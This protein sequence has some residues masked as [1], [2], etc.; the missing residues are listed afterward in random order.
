MERGCFACA[1]I[2]ALASGLDAHEAHAQRAL[3]ATALAPNAVRIDGD[4]GD[5]RGL[6]FAELGDDKSGSL[7]YALGADDQA[8]YLAARVHDDDFVRGPAVSPQQ[9]ALVLTFWLPSP[10][11]G[12][13]SEVW[14]YAGVPGQQ[15]SVAEIGPPGGSA[16]P[17]KQV[18]VVEG[19]LAKGKGYVLEARVP[20][21]ALPGGQNRALARAALRLHDVDGKAG[22]R[23]TV[24][25]SASAARPVQLPE[26]LLEG[27]PNASVRAFLAHKQLADSSVRHD[28]IGQVAGDA[29][30][31]RVVVAGT[32][33]LVAGSDLDAAAGYHFMDLP[34]TS[35]ADVLAAELRDL[36]GD[37]RNELV[38]RLEQRD[39]LGTRE[40]VDVLALAPGRPRVLF[41]AV[42][43]RRTEQGSVEAKLAF[44]PAAGGKPAALALAI[45]SA[46]GLDASSYA[47]RPP[48]GIEP[49]MTPWGA[50]ARRVYR[51]DGKR[52][53]VASEQLNPDAAKS[54][55][56]SAGAGPSAS[57]QPPS[58][59]VPRQRASGA[60]SVVHAEPPGMDQLVA[61]FRADRAIERSLRARFVQHANV[62][63]DKRIESLM[64]FGKDLLVIGKGFRDGTGYFYFGLPVQDG[65]DVQRLFTADVTGDGRRELFV[66]H[67]Q[68][69][70]DVQREL[71]LV[72]RFDAQ[73]IAPLLRVEVRRAQASASVGNVVDIVRDGKHWALRISPGAARSWDASNYPFVTD[74]S[75]EYAPLLLPWRDRAVRY[76]FDG[77]AL[78]AR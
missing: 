69:I 43:G 64:L 40:L 70:G 5:F 52:F 11:G 4:L 29:R 26:L 17:S 27:G 9:D 54:T 68:R 62:A 59:S 39:E 47:E 61:A 48:A 60:E 18:S 53:A 76:R 15:A 38:L 12:R 31:E 32:F 73:G 14:L 3:Q 6:R 19:P 25:A 63:E 66:R 44:E 78:V 45:G 37:G 20:W 13:A 55:S 77:A 23:A 30:L 2:C 24:V 72:Y 49:L 16:S 56:P 51:W 57:A 75:D 10:G 21:S 71:L 33:V 65:S 36:T 28:L 22:T 50:V 35:A 8:L 67:K 46:R 41:A 42:L 34:V 58:S 74:A 1:L 7:S